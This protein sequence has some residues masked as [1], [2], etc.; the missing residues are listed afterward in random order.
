[1]TPTATASK[2]N[3]REDDVTRPCA[4]HSFLTDIADVREMEQGLLQLLQDFHA[5]KLQVFGSADAFEKMDQV[6][7]QQERLARLHFELD[8][9]QHMKGFETQRGRDLINKNLSELMEHLQELC[10]SVQNINKTK[11]HS[12]PWDPKNV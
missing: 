9:A 11:L 8:T 3:E 5:G 2:D 12:Q 1:M 6:R 7:E 4:E 10:E